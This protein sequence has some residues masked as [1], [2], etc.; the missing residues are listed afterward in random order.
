MKYLSP[1]IQWKQGKGLPP[2]IP[3][4]SLSLGCPKN[5]VD[6]EHLL[7]SLGLPVKSVSQ[8]G[9]ARLVFINTCGFIAP[10]VQESVRA[11]VDAIERLAR[12]K[13]KPL[14]A[15]A[16][17][18]VG[19]YGQEELARELPEVDVWLP[20]AE[21]PHWA[22][23]LASKLGLAEAGQG[24]LLSTGPSYAWLKVG[25]GCRHSCAFCTIPSIRGRLRSEPL[26]ILKAE[27]AQLVA[28]GVRELALVAQD[29]TSWGQ[30]LPGKPSLISLLESLLTLDGLGWLRLLYLYPA[31]V[32]EELLRFI[33][34]AGPPLLPYLD[35][36]LQ[37]AHPD[38]LSRMGRPF[39]DDPR[40]VL[41]RVRHILPDAALRTSLIVGYPGESEAHFEHLCR[42]VEEAEFRQLG[43]FAYQ[44]EEGTRAASL[45]NQVPEAVREERRNSLME[46]QAD[47]S[48]SWL[49]RQVGQRLPVLVDSPH[50]EWPGLH[51]G[52]VWFQAPEVDGVTYVSGPGVAP[53]A[54]LEC[55][56]V[57]NTAYDLTALA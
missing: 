38:I 30:D 23:I 9:R 37:H 46:L 31:G 50:E 40:R 35:I 5:R 20:P 32:T 1:S 24:R 33:R 19:R 55:D 15:V 53:G 39:A 45:P 51:L 17:C 12:C 27:A 13:R 26:D 52:R 3:V 18:L 22:R 56:I 36:P 34:D 7:G 43:V 41:D 28:S 44:A 14:L 6:S 42:F 48:E 8:M 21:L 47:I 57:E 2:A 4:W 11:V 49:A 29:V 54:L 10:A 25:E 16:G